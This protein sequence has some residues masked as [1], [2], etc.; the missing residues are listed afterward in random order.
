MEPESRAVRVEWATLGPTLFGLTL[1]PVGR[2]ADVEE[3]V[4]R[5]ELQLT[6]DGQVQDQRVERQDVPAAAFNV[7]VPLAPELLRGPATVFVTLRLAGSSGTRWAGEAALLSGRELVWREDVTLDVGADGDV[8]WERIFVSRA[9]QST[10]GL[11]AGPTW[12][13][14]ARML[15]AE[16]EDA[17]DTPEVEGGWVD[18]AAPT[19][20]R[21]GKL[22]KVWYATDRKPVH[23]DSSFVGYA[24]ERDDRTHHGACEV[25]IPKWHRIGTTTSS[26]W[27]VLRGRDGTLRVTRIDAMAADAFWHGVAEQVGR[28]PGEFKHAAVFIH[29]YRVTFR[30][31]AIRAAQL[32]VDL[33]INGAMGFF[34]W[35]SEGRLLGYTRDESAIEGSELR[36]E[37]FL[38]DFAA[39][40]GA[41]ALHV[42]AHSM[43]NRAL[44]RAVDRI[45]MRARSTS[46]TVLFGHIVLAAPDVTT[47]L[48]KQLAAAYQ[49]IARRTTLYVSD[50]D[51]ALAVSQFLHGSTRLGDSG[52]GAIVV[53]AIDTVVATAVDQSFLGHGY[54]AEAREVLT[55]V[56]DL[57]Y[58]DA[59]PDK[60]IGLERVESEHGSYWVIQA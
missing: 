13:D 38:T 39:R 15:G 43:G 12:R 4:A 19:I 52:D 60:R 31:A 27:D 16:E 55:D 26:F 50:K 23:V 57:I 46:P 40:S 3:Q 47:T 5:L 20:P 36:I 22:Y 33:K 44:L 1:E 58:Y 59:P 24:W 9:P 30:E 34:A 29:G 7:D 21:D 8:V 18:E 49:R 54:V 28:A 6:I 45:V 56:H 25:L 32:G 51:R 2:E 35:P 53:G 42:I 14:V 10:P 41:D 48:F 11:P 37:E 17:A